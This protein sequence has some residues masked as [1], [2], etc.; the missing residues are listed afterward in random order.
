MPA[1][2]NSKKEIALPVIEDKG[3]ITPMSLL[4]K[5][6]NKQIVTDAFPGSLRKVKKVSKRLH[7]KKW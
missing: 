3:P 4:K 6:L 5:Y 1:K 7:Y 2:K